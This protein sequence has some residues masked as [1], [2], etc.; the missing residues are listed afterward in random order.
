MYEYA[1][2][3]QGLP[4]ASFQMMPVW[5]DTT[6]LYSRY[7]RC[8]YRN[9]CI[10]APVPE[11]LILNIKKKNCLVDATDTPVKHARNPASDVA[12]A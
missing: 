1:C 11:T 5:P 10:P 4:P 3:H 7:L 6:S 2:A 9:E 12:Q 8:H